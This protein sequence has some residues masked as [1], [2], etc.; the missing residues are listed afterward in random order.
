MKT[1]LTLITILFAFLMFS[2]IETDDNQSPLPEEAICNTENPL[3]DLSW[4]KK[5][6]T[7]FETREICM[8]AQ[9]ISYDYFGEDVFWIDGCYNCPDNMISIYNCSGEIICEIGGI[10]GQN[11]CPDFFEIAKDSTMLFNSVQD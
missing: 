3:E 5:I 7:T 1:K 8:G 10:S 6:K 2:C 4:L 11:N 9:I